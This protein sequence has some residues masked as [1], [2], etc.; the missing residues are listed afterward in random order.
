MLRP[1]PQCIDGA[2][3]ISRNRPVLSCKRE[4]RRHGYYVVKC[5]FTPEHLDHRGPEGAIQMGSQRN[6]SMT[7]EKLTVA[8]PDTGDRT[9]L[10]C[11][12]CPHAWDAHDPIGIRYCSATVAG[13]FNRGC[14]CV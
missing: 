7:E 4:L 11:A 9:C 13:G 3:A 5:A 14:V 2:V 1:H 6:M 12:A 10:T 8:E